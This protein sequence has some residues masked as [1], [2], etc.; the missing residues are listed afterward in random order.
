MRLKKVLSK[1][2]S[3]VIASAMVLSLM[4]ATLAFADENRIYLGFNNFNDGNLIKYLDDMYDADDD[5]WINASEVTY[6]EITDGFVY[7]LTGIEL[8]PNLNLLTIRNCEL[9]SFAPSSE[10]PNLYDVDLIGNDLT[11]VDLTNTPNVITLNVMDNPNLTSIDLGSDREL[12]DAYLW[13]LC[14]SNPYDGYEVRRVTEGNYEKYMFYDL[15][16]DITYTDS[17][18]VYFSYGAW[19]SVPGAFSDANWEAYVANEIDLNHDGYLTQD[20]R[21]AVTGI[22]V[23]GLGISSIERLSLFPNLAYLDCSDNNITEL[24]FSGCLRL[25]GLNCSNNQLEVLDVAAL[26]IL[27]SCVASDNQISDVRFCRNTGLMVFNVAN[28]PLE[29]ID[30]SWAPNIEVLTV[31][32][33][34]LTGLMLEYLPNLT[35]LVANN[36]ES[37]DYLEFTSNP[38]L[39]YVDFS[40]SAVENIY[41]GETIHSNLSYLYTHDTNLELVELTGCQHLI[42]L[43]ESVEPTTDGSALIYYDRDN[44]AKFTVDSSTEVVFCP[45]PTTVKINEKYFP[46]ANLRSWVSSHVDTNNNGIIDECLD[47][48]EMDLSNLGIS[49]LGGLQFFENLVTLNL[50]GNN[51]DEIYFG[52]YDNLVSL[53][54]SNNN[55]SY[56]DVYLCPYLQYVNTVGNVDAVIYFSACPQISYAYFAGSYFVE[57]PEDDHPVVNV[58]FDQYATTAVGEFDVR[59]KYDLNSF[60]NIGD[61]EASEG[62]AP[63]MYGMDSVLAA[64]MLENFDV[65]GDGYLSMGERNEVTEINVQ[66]YGISSL[67]GLHCFPYLNYI[68]ASDN[69]LTEVDLSLNRYV[70]FANFAHNEI[71]DINVSTNFVLMNLNVSYNAIETISFEYTDSIETLTLAGNPISEIDISGLPFLITLDVSETPVSDIDIPVDSDIRFIYTNNCVNITTLDVTNCAWIQGIS[72]MNSSVEEIIFAE[73]TP[74]YN[75]AELD[76]SGSGIETI[77]ITYLPYIQYV[78]EEVEPNIY[79]GCMVHT[80]LNPDYDPEYNMRIYFSYDSENEIISGE[81]QEPVVIVARIDEETFPDRI[82]REFVKQFDLDEDGWLSFDEI[83]PVT[84]LNLDDM[85]IRDLTGIENFWCLETLSAKN[86]LFSEVKL[87]DLCFITNLDLRNNPNMSLLD[88]SGAWASVETYYY[89]DYVTSTYMDRPV[90]E[91]SRLIIESEEEGGRTINGSLKY[92]AYVEIDYNNENYDTPFFELERGIEDENFR[93]Y[94]AEAFD[95][96]NDGYL[97]PAELVRNYIDCS[98]MD[99]SSLKGIHVF[100]D[101]ITLNCSDNNIANLDLSLAFC[102]DR[103][104]C[105]NNNIATLKLPSFGAITYIDCS[106]NKITALDLSGTRLYELYASGNQIKTLDLSPCKYLVELDVSDNPLTSL[107]LTGCKDLQRLT[108]TNVYG[109]KEVKLTDCTSLTYVSF[110]D[111]SLEK[112][113]LDGEEY[114]DLKILILNASD[115]AEVDI[116]NCPLLIDV[117]L[118]GDAPEM[119]YVDRHYMAENGNDIDSCIRI[120][121]DTQVVYGEVPMAVEADNGAD[122]FLIRMYS[123][124]L[125]RDPDV[126]GREYYLKKIDNGTTGATVA[127]SFLVSEEFLGM[128]LSN[129]AFVEILYAACFNRSAS[130]AERNYWV[131]YL[132]RG[133]TRKK[134]IEYFIESEEFA[135]LCASNGI[136][137]GTRTQATVPMAPNR[138]IIDFCNRLY[139]KCLGRELDTAGR[140]WWANKLNGGKVTGTR[141]AHDFFFSNEFVEEGYDDTE[142]VLRL[143][144]T[145]Y[146][147]VPA[148]NEIAYWVGALERGMDR[149]KLFGYFI[150][151]DEWR[152]LCARYHINP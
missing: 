63:Y 31:S 43:Y 46:D 52:A 73:Q 87:Y 40:G 6:I 20:E 32:G 56:I 16:V 120:N 109:I 8:F 142:F 125:A 116:T 97:S 136:N 1:A 123:I 60:F 106:N 104:E 19:E 3:A 85:G 64:Y 48:T 21:R 146:D 2:V 51:L 23:S 54:L 7:D 28:N 150:N 143:Y 17:P 4:P 35:T 132:E 82:F 88:L 18:A 24:D 91:F 107:T 115:V 77:D 69:S 10:M 22:N 39:Y 67:R 66:S 98:A 70:A 75:L 133:G 14:Y 11:T 49:N 62:Y 102:L 118:H 141:A 5:N 92:D 78:Y 147:R 128:D 130:I 95:D 65:D 84:E 42:D 96:D 74:Y 41:F 152:T 103:L 129:E 30:T 121:G 89:G 71:T 12:I 99:I 55:A 149:E 53:D 144:A 13:G 119:G 145:I 38:N 68:D 80:A 100:D 83:R 127:K 79:G 57:Y 148:Q 139:T 47:I 112:I 27:Q 113:V 81:M 138:L 108:A 151:S 15:G 114:A 61:F 58:G 110:F 101:L 9:T 33:T 117:Y 37:L 137:P 44:D 105:A 76:I 93:T 90:V 126:G 72:V 45:D 94:L 131:G 26:K 36:C 86:N 59:I 25:S 135:N 122:A 34:N 111:S 29:Y 134:A 124:A 50:S 140:D